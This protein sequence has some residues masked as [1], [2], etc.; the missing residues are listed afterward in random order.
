M[1]GPEARY[2][3][4]ELEALEVVVT[5][6]HFAY[7]LYGREFVVFTDH[8]PLCHLLTS[9]RLNARLRWLAM[10]LQQWMVSIEYLP[11]RDNSAVDDLSRQERDKEDGETKPWGPPS[12][13]EGCGGPAPLRRKE[14]TL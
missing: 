9:E 10:K 5:L 1:R 7:Y 6:G 11:G 12:D 4:T 3:A 13:G 8:K 14:E 2:S